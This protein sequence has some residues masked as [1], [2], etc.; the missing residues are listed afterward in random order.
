M[1]ISYIKNPVRDH[2]NIFKTVNAR[3]PTIKQETSGNYSKSNV[4][5]LLSKNPNSP[6]SKKLG[7]AITKYWKS[8]EICCKE[9]GVR[10]YLT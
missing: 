2:T 8:M 1:A 7:K 4:K 6:I 5:Y 3:K 10:N 9:L